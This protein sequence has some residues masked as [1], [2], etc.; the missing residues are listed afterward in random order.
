MSYADPKL[1]HTVTITS[2]YDAE[3]EMWDHPSIEFK[4]TALYG[5]CHFY[6]QCDCESFGVDHFDERGPGHERV[7]HDECWLTAWFDNP[8]STSYAGEDADHLRSD[9]GIPDGMNRTGRI[10]A[11][12]EYGEYVEWEFVP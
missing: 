4:C 7:H 6:P 1:W 12:C 11:A 3:N 5:D 10:K 8:E 9:Y 2:H